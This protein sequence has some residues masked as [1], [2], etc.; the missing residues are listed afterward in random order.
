MDHLHPVSFGTSAVR[1]Y[2]AGS[3]ASSNGSA[4]SSTSVHDTAAA[5]AHTPSTSPSLSDRSTSSSHAPSN[6]SKLPQQP[7]QPASSDSSS[8]ASSGLSPLELLVKRGMQVQQDILTPDD[9]D[10]SDSSSHRIL[11]RASALS[12]KTSVRKPLIQPSPDPDDFDDAQSIRSVNLLS[13]AGSSFSRGQR[14]SAPSSAAASPNP[15][16]S[17]SVQRGYKASYDDSTDSY[18]PTHPESDWQRQ[19]SHL[20]S[21]AFRNSVA[22]DISF[23]SITG[24]DLD[25]SLSR[26]ASIDTV[27]SSEFGEHGRWGRAWTSR[28]EDE[29]SL[30]GE[31]AYGDNYD[32]DPDGDRSNAA[33]AHIDLDPSRGPLRSNLGLDSVAKQWKLDHAP[34]LASTGTKSSRQNTRSNTWAASSIPAIREVA[35]K[36]KIVSLTRSVPPPTTTSR[37]QQPIVSHVAAD[38]RHSFVPQ[39]E[40]HDYDAPPHPSQLYDRTPMAS[41]DRHLGHRST[42]ST[43]TITGDSTRADNDS[44]PT[45]RVYVYPPSPSGSEASTAPGAAAQ[46]HHNPTLPFTTQQRYVSMPSPTSAQVETMAAANE[47]E[48][49]RTPLAPSSLLSNPRSVSAGSAGSAG[50]Q[51]PRSSGHPAGRVPPPPPPARSGSGDE[52]SPLGYADPNQYFQGVDRPIIGRKRA[53]AIARADG[54]ESMVSDLDVETL[55]LDGSSRRD[56]SSTIGSAMTSRMSIGSVSHDPATLQSAASWRNSQSGVSPK[57]SQS[58][59]RSLQP[60]QDTA[61]SEDAAR[62]PMLRNAKSANAIANGPAAGSGSV[63]MQPTASAPPSGLGLGLGGANAAAAAKPRTSPAV[64]TRTGPSSAE[65]F[66]SQGITYHEQGDLARSAF[67][68]ERSAKVD[69]GC[70]VGMCMFGMA[71]REGWG[72]RKDPVKGFTW[73]QRAAARAGEMMSTTSSPKTDSEL[74]AIK[75]ELKLSV[76]E[77]GKCFCYGWGVK[78]DKHMALEYFELAAKLGDV[79]AQAEA[80]ALYAAGKGCKKDLKKA[81]MYYR[82]A[83]AGGYDTVGLSWIHKDK[84]K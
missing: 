16:S 30:Y 7:H 47:R 6:W 73:I 4:S 12:R 17:F 69:G 9:G 75:S 18:T 66:L 36:E 72:A 15:G 26:R 65:D 53:E 77:L 83:E 55:R 37:L 23:N 43:A 59:F 11:E 57:P 64:D 33:D 45:A 31:S 40:T 1:S 44:P 56:S 78:M 21:N 51:R 54:R 5:T 28:A 42:S 76:Y 49:Q 84:Y 2:S 25:S 27:R 19:S 20:L 82:M 14:G 38:P 61:A 74:K 39:I 67:Y 68:F 41:A 32:H 60:V 46:H 35:S 22:S 8:G 62:L 29:E 63:A 58:S 50:S 3:Y 52:R 34:H 80:G 13:D 70:V 24:N 10:T 79:D 81:A 48:A 71:L